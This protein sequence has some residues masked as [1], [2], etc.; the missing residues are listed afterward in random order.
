MPVVDASVVFD[1]VAPDVDAFGP[2][3]RWL[4][5]LDPPSGD[6]IAPR[7][8]VQEVGNGLL[9]SIR[10][11]RF[12]GAAADG[13]FARLQRLP[14]RLIDHDADL[15]R[16][17]DLARRYDDHPLYDM[18]YVALAERLRTTLITAD[19]ALRTRLGDPPW[20]GLPG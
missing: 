6:L 1:W 20:I 10:R 2:A 13:A 5:R 18:V 12:T 15:Q 9:R 19:A 7:L 16:A 11:R 4:R 17:W 3:M 8:V 14:L